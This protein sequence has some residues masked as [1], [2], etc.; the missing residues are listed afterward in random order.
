MFSAE[1]Q[2]E[3]HQPNHILSLTL[4]NI[5]LTKPAKWP[6]A[7]SGH[8]V[9]HS[10]HHETMARMSCKVLPQGN[11]ELGPIACALT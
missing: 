4:V 9:I 3:G 5:P 6:S 8:W 7:K 2:K 11:E 10:A 1:V